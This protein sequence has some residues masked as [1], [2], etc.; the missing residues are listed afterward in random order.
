MN[1]LQTRIIHTHDIEANWD[2]CETFIPKE[3]E[4]IVYDADETVA[5]S[6]FKIGDGVTP[7]TMLSFQTDEVL[8]DYFKIS[9]NVAIF[10][11]GRITSYTEWGE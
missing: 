1:T 10:D 7:V 3:G 5:Y 9:N 11:A 8:N 6:R 4:L 2:L